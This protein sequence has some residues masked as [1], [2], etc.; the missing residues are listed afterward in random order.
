MPAVLPHTARQFGR[1]IVM[2]NLKPPVTTTAQA[3]AYRERIPA[4]LPAGMTFEP[5]MT[6]YLTDNTPPDEIRRARKRLRARREA[7][8]GGRDDEFR[9]RRHR[10][11]EMREGSSRRCRKPACRCSCTAR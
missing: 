6:L 5:L 3:Q 11:R 10:S 9:P 8:S 2:P 7:V 4:A 1:A